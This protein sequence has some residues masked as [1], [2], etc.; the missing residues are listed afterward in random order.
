MQHLAR[1]L[2]RRNVR[3]PLG[4]DPETARTVELERR[5]DLAGIGLGE[6]IQA[7]FH[8][9]SLSVLLSSS[10]NSTTAA[11]SPLDA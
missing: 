3:Q 7:V 11:A 9:C 8:S 5:Q 4:R 1:K 2:P 6:Q 10:I